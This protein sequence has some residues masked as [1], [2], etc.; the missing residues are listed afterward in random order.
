MSTQS[1]PD[2]EQVEEGLPELQGLGFDGSELAP[3]LTEQKWQ[4]VNRYGFIAAGVHWFVP[5]GLY[6]EL[7]THCKIAPL[8]NAPAHVLGLT[9]VR[10][11]LVPVYQLEPLVDLP[12]VAPSYVLVLGELSHAAGLVVAAKP[13]PIP[14]DR[15]QEVSGD[16]DIADSLRTTV[17]ES[18]SDGSRQWHTV[19]HVRLFSHLAEQT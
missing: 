15:L 6:S 8:P 5:A 19:D 16:P 3:T 4:R 7:L 13:Q 9:N 18:L 1:V 17:A 2:P 10:G 12:S 11:N 14:E